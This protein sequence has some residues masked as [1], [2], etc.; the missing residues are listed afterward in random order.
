MMKDPKQIKSSGVKKLFN[1]FRIVVINEETFEEKFIFKLSPITIILGTIISIIF[2]SSITYITI[3]YS[4]I[5]EFIPGYTSTKMRIKAI[6]NAI[7]IDSI[8]QNIKKQQ[9]YLSSIKSAL[10]G[11]IQIEE[12][13]NLST[14][15]SVNQLKSQPETSKEDSILR[16]KVAEED[17]YN[18]KIDSDDKRILLL[19]TP[20]KGIISEK[21]NVQNKHYAVDIALQENEP[22]KSVSEGT[23]IFSE[24]TAETGYVIIIEHSSGLISVYKH[25]SSLTKH[26]GD[27]VDSGEVIALAGNTGEYS[28][29][30]HLHFELWTDG[31]PLDPEKFID[32]SK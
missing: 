5:R 31:Y 21:F 30:Y 1:Q 27:N 15:E 23:V 13:T 18:V 14:D 2:I 4:P 28:S 22:I 12:I 9:R 32:F 17:K 3:A 16:A 11:E 24:W 10:S 26:Q 8:T 6:S 19:F 29:G 25:N 7:K 20:A